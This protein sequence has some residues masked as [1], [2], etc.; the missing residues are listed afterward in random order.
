MVTRSDRGSL[1]IYYHDEPVPARDGDTIAAALIADGI[2]S[3]RLTA[4]EQRR[5]GPF[6]MMGACMECLAEVDG[7]QNVQT[8]MT[9]VRDGMH[10]V[11][12]KAHRV[13]PDREDG[14]CSTPQDEP[15]YQERLDA[16]RSLAKHL[17][18]VKAQAIADAEKDIEAEG[19]TDEEDD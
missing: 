10:V 14:V 1:T 13:L 11:T 8:C 3:F 18:Q 6:C 17:Y 16:S 19:L 15:G 2:T 5:R 7:R 9:K 4:V 12:Q